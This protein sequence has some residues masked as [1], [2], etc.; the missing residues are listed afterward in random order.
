MS[1]ATTSRPACSCSSVP[2]APRGC[3]LWRT[4]TRLHA[5]VEGVALSTMRVQGGSGMVGGVAC[6]CC[7]SDSAEPAA[8]PHGRAIMH[9]PAHCCMAARV[10]RPA[11]HWASVRASKAG[12]VGKGQR[13]CP[14]VLGDMRERRLPALR[15]RRVQGRFRGDSSQAMCSS[16]AGADS[17]SQ[18]T[19]CAP[20]RLGTSLAWSR[21]AVGS[22]VTVEA[23]P[24][25]PGRLPLLPRY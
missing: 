25:S 2:E 4:P 24:Q 19:L 7:T 3:S 20:P 23:L 12:S 15:P 17:S 18:P 22:R 6:C 21:R 13:E 16:S 9:T 1:A 11:V 8:D 5:C 10:R 14:R